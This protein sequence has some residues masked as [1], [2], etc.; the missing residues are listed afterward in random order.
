M[1]F[2][3]F[4]S[5][6]AISSRDTGSIVININCDEIEFQNIMLRLMSKAL[7]V[8]IIT[9]DGLDDLVDLASM[10]KGEVDALVGNDLSD[11]EEVSD[12]E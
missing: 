8:G 1:L 2:D 11:E 6:C 12:D 3:N 4:S 10:V 5:V 7:V 9:A